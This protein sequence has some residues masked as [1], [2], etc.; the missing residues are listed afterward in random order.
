VIKWR[1]VVPK[2]DGG[3]PREGQ[4]QRKHGGGYAELRQA[5]SSAR[6]RFEQGKRG[7]DIGEGEG[8]QWGPF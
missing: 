3:L 1:G 7:G 6:W 8:R 4:N 5:N 2:R